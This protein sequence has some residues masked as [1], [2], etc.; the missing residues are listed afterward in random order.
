AWGSRCARDGTPCRAHN[1]APRGDDRSA[2]QS[3]LG[4]RSSDRSRRLISGHGLTSADGP[5]HGATLDVD[6]FETLSFEELTCSVATRPGP[7]DDIRRSINGEL[8]ERRR[9]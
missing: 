4:R 6:A 5:C 8:I 9:Y 2:L 3:R 7:A 1:A